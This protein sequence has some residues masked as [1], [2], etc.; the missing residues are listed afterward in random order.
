MTATTSIRPAVKSYLID[1][2]SSLLEPLQAVALRTWDGKKL[3]RSTVWI[4]RTTGTVEF[5]FAQ[6]GRKD[7]NDDFTVRLVFAA[8]HPGEDEIE[9]E[10]RVMAMFAKLEDL[11][12]DD[13]S[14]G[15]LDGLVHMTLGATEGPDTFPNG[16]QGF[17]AILEADV[18]CRSRL[19]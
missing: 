1:Q 19:L 14:A 4:R 8:V 6:A 15:D 2:L 13:V 7:R 12:A 11:I 5:P 16:D 17:G 18:D 9:A 10:E 3:D